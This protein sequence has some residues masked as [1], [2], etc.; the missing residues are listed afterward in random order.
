MFVFLLC[1]DSELTL[2]LKSLPISNVVTRATF[3]T[4]VIVIFGGGGGVRESVSVFC[5][6]VY[7]LIISVFPQHKF[8][9]VGCNCACV[10]ASRRR[11][12]NEEII[13]ILIISII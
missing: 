13:M 3:Q 2:A 11:S 12:C 5:A 7:I 6:S 10:E 1:L 8:S 4:A 9:R